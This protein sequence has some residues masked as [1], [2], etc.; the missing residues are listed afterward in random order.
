MEG[1][2]TFLDEETNLMMEV[3]VKIKIQASNL[4]LMEGIITSL[5]R[6]SKIHDVGLLNLASGADIMK[7]LEVWNTSTVLA[8][9][10]D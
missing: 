3:R 6:V 5:P 2:V 10:T 1:T 4:E 9:L 7:Q 8:I